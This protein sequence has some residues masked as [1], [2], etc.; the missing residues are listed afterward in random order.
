MDNQPDKPIADISSMS[1]KV[2]KFAFNRAASA[3]EK[4][5]NNK[6]TEKQ[7]K[8]KLTENRSNIPVEN[9]SESSKSSMRRIANVEITVEGTVDK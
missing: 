4:K 5:N 8:S 1:L 7:S 3:V 9:F 6:L 2:I